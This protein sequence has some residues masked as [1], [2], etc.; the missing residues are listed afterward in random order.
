LPKFSPSIIGVFLLAA[1]SPSLA[2]QDRACAV[3]DTTKL[4]DEPFLR[5]ASD[6]EDGAI[7][8][9][10]G[11]LEAS[12]GSNPGASMSGGVLIR[13]GDRLAGAE[14]ADYDPATQSLQ[15]R[16]QVRYED[17][18]TSITSDSAELT[19]STGR[20]FFEG[21]EFQLGQ[22]GSRGSA[23]KIEISREGTLSLGD[24]EYTTCPPGSN[25]W[26][27]EAGD[28]TLDTNEG[29]G[30][31]KKVVLRFQGVPILYAPTLTFP[32]GD[33]R[34][35]GIL[36]PEIGSAGRSGYEIRVPWYWNISEQYDATVTPRLL[37]DRGLQIGTEFRYLTRR[38][39]GLAQYEYLADDRVFGD[40]RQYLLFRHRTL[41]DNGWRNLIDY[42]K[43][44]DGNY[45]EDLGGSLS[46]T[47]I[48]N[49]NRSA[50]FDY[51]GENWSFLGRV[52][53][54][55]TIDESIADVDR[56]YRRLP[57]MYAS[58]TWPSRPL[59]LS[60]SVD[61]ELVYFDRDVGTTGWRFNTRPQV[62]W[63][64]QR[65]GW[66]LKP[67]VAFDHTRYSLENTEPN[68]ADDE[69]RSL[70]IS[71]VDIGM[72]LE[73][74]IGSTKKRIQTLEPRLLYVHVPHREQ[75]GLPVFDT[76]EPDL[77]LVQLFRTN[78]FLGIDRI[79][80]TDQL[81]VGITTRLMDADTGREVITATIGQ[82]LY[83]SDQRVTL[84]GQPMTNSESSDYIAELRVLLYKN[85]SF[86]IGHQW[87]NDRTG[88][89]RSEV[90]L[91]YRPAANKVLNLGYRFRRDSLEQGDVS[92]SWPL[93][94]SWNFVGRYN[95]SL[96]DSKPLERFVGL[97]Y[98]S[99]CWGIRM[100]S[101]HYVSTRDGFE[102]SSFG[103]QLVLKGM[104]SVG[105]STDRL[106]ERGILGYSRDFE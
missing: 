102:E 94:Q 67:A 48:T 84:P 4:G 77:N 103:I 53:D 42:R 101:R 93:T 80:D 91:Q 2:Q 44:S 11:R 63:D 66:F 62:E 7:I 43:T 89:T 15:L 14:T 45:F 3:Q 75:S 74:S 88:T 19:Y 58:G 106:L 31:A 30:T 98:E 90:A 104:A 68:Q 72:I 24:V 105:D 28:I 70:P 5:Q 22:G 54:Y 41:F 18:N 32:L 13:R 8:F 50:L 100:V 38:N 27:L 46:T 60:Y 82:A 12:V 69:T 92:W 83:L 40:T 81:S 57:Q 9:E 71:S 61:G 95:Y 86:D 76:I 52:Q 37:T 64:L 47:S 1:V 85:F 87:A 29:V 56:P 59:G 99:C 33:A 78:R 16:G 20:V 10:A 96:R 79:A 97:E 26:L 17:P 34:K 55:Q 6:A 25:D 65:P 73:R 36:A 35:T 39:D 51:Y 23:E 21:A 49:L